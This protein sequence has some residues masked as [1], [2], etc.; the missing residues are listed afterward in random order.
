MKWWYW[1]I[2]EL[3]IIFGVMAWIY[4]FSSEIADDFAK[5]MIGVALIYTI[6]ECKEINKRSR[7]SENYTIEQNTG[8]N[9]IEGGVVSISGSI[10][11]PDDI[12]R[13]CKTCKNPY[14]SRTIAER[15]AKE[16]QHHFQYGWECTDKEKYLQNDGNFGFGFADK[17]EL[18]KQLQS[19]KSYINDIPNV[20]NPCKQCGVFKKNDRFDYDTIK[21]GK[22]IE[23]KCPKCC[24]FYPSNFEVGV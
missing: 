22:V 10:D 21:D 3:L 5:G 24:W 1:L 18:K 20:I 12:K 15:Q 4:F 23:G 17:Q 19:Y 7:M 14:C 16:V 2:L 11:I 8:E 13:E 6:E 9:Q